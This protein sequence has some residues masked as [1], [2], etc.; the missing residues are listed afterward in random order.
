MRKKAVALSIQ[1]LDRHVPA[2][3][4]S[5]LK[6]RVGAQKCLVLG[7]APSPALPD[8]ANDF[9]VVSVNGSAGSA[10]LHGLASPIFSVLDS[11]L[12]DPEIY[13]SKPGRKAVH[14]SEVL[15]GRSLGLLVQHRSNH[16]S[17]FNEPKIVG[18]TYD[19]EFRLGR[20]AASRI[21]RKVGKS[22]LLGRYPHGLISNGALA[23]ALCAW[24]GAETVFISG[25]RLTFP[26]ADNMA[27]HFYDRPTTGESANSAFDTRNHALADSLLLSSLAARGLHLDSLE[28]QIAPLL[29]NHGMSKPFQSWTPK[30]RR[31]WIRRRPI[32]KN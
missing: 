11:E 25:F 27:P 20:E 10:A 4:K 21:V 7:S 18:A 24:A 15:R 17:R 2:K 13:G 5:E 28:P 22:S 32:R 1:F 14:D 19:M 3:L 8:D 30:D 6:A 31:A 9:L 23:V 12:F 26:A 16:F 29:Y